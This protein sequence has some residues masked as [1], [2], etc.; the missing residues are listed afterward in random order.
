M[1][2]DFQ[3][4]ASLCDIPC[5]DSECPILVDEKS[6]KRLLGINQLQPSKL[7]D[8]FTRAEN[9][10]F[11]SVWPIS[12][13]VGVPVPVCRKPACTPSEQSPDEMVPGSGVWPGGDGARR[14][15]PA[16]GL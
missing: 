5:P 11:V 3:V 6:L 8:A 4:E 13:L 7:L 15:L 14:R 2:V 9:N 16:S 10:D 12:G 1:A